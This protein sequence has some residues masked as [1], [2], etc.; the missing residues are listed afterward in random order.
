MVGMMIMLAT[1]CFINE[2]HELGEGVV[3]LSART[4]T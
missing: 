3:Y 4:A 2:G 1:A